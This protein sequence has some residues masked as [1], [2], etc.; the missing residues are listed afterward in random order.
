MEGRTFLEE[1][2]LAQVEGRLAARAI[3]RSVDLLFSVLALILLSPLLLLIAIAIKLES[4]GP[5][6]FRQRRMGRHGD[7]FG[8]LKFRTMV[9]GADAEK[10]KLMHLNEAGGGLFKI[11]GDPRVTRVGKLLRSTSL[12]ELPQLWNVIRGEMSLVGPRPL[13]TEE[14]ALISGAHRRRLELRPGLTGVWQVAGASQVPLDEMCELDL[15]YVENWSPWGDLGL[16]IRTVPHVIFR[17]GV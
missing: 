7:D 2:G 14:D 6:L 10:Q 3:K 16:M 13:V 11:N 17:R 1:F 9:D 15:A 12:D 8:M 4:P 5:V